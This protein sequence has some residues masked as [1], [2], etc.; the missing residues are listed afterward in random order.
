MSEFTTH[1][2]VI[3]YSWGSPISLRASYYTAAQTGLEERIKGP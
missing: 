3:G 2:R 1:P